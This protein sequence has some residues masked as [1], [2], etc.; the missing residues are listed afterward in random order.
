MFR[1]FSEHV[2]EPELLLGHFRIGWDVVVYQVQDESNDTSSMLQPL[3][4]VGTE[5]DSVGFLKRIQSCS[6]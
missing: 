2:G 5:T 1:A 6:S 4:V 3:L